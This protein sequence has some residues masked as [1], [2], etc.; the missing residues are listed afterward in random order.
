MR[1]F[2]ACSS[3]HEPAG[4]DPASASCTPQNLT[5]VQHPLDDPAC[6]IPLNLNQHPPKPKPR[7][8]PAPPR[9]R[10]RAL[11]P[12]PRPPHPAPKDSRSECRAAGRRGIP[13]RGMGTGTTL[14][15][16]AESWAEPGVCGRP[17]ENLTTGT[18]VHRPTP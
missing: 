11:V 3:L 18:T 17:A 4:L 12:S 9:P 14:G 6:R 10:T 13:S 16:S 2:P 15:Y 8:K 5:S 7:P 1:A